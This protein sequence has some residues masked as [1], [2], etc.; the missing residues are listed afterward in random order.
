MATAARVPVI[1]RNVVWV[2][3]RGV[4]A[5]IAGG[6]AEVAWIYAYG[7]LTGLD[8]GKVAFGVSAAVGLGPSSAPVLSGIAIHIALAASLGVGLVAALRGV[9]RYL[10]GA[11]AIY[12]AALTALVGVWAINFLL[13]LPRLSPAFIHLL[14]FQVSLASKLLFGLAA[15]CVFHS[16]NSS[17]PA[18]R[19]CRRFSRNL[20]Q[21]VGV[22]R[23][24][25]QNSSCARYRLGTPLNGCIEFA[26]DAG[27]EGSEL[28][29]NGLRE[30]QSFSG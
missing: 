5:G 9:H 27:P 2:V 13:V 23:R 15:A 3:G 17:R 22:S 26:S 29:A 14:P 20:S 25:V 12:V 6:L 24:T 16:A 28:Q 18:Y 19:I 30:E 10:P 7:E 1:N 21:A 8:A 11:A 4:L